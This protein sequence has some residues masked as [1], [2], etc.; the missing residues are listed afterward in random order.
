[1]FKENMGE[2][3]LYLINVMDSHIWNFKKNVIGWSRVRYI[4]GKVQNPVGR[5]YLKS[6]QNEND[7]IPSKHSRVQSKPLHA[8]GGDQA[9]RFAGQ[10]GAVIPV[11]RAVS[12]RK[13]AKNKPS[14]AGTSR[15][16]QE[17]RV[18][19]KT[20]TQAIVSWETNLWVRYAEGV[21]VPVWAAFSVP[22]ER[23]RRNDHLTRLQ[24]QDCQGAMCFGY[25]ARARPHR[26]SSYPHH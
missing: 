12:N 13:I 25:V 17:S 11:G 5:D 14:R 8:A 7:R 23:T 24:L 26:M 18:C 16:S 6:S 9:C 1:M 2:N 20:G 19:G 21:G 3:I 10:V 4:S 22:T 15:R